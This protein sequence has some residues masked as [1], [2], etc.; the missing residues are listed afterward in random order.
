MHRDLHSKNV[1]L[2]FGVKPDAPTTPWGNIVSV[3]I[4]DLG[5]ASF[6]QNVVRVALIDY[7]TAECCALLATPPEVLFRQGTEWRLKAQSSQQV[8]KSPFPSARIGSQ[9][10]SIGVQPV[11]HVDVYIAKKQPR[12]CTYDSKVDIW[13]LGILALT[14]AKGVPYALDSKGHRLAFEMVK[15][16]GKIPKATVHLLQWSVPTPY[17]VQDLLAL[18]M[19]FPEVYFMHGLL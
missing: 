15:V 10:A 1:L 6:V 11:H 17:T 5:K 18:P 7:L 2:K 13:A 14:L 8:G 19:Y 4:A 3:K 12:D 9:L 16:F